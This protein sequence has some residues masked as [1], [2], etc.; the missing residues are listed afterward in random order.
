MSELAGRLAPSNGECMIVVRCVQCASLVD[1]GPFTAERLGALT[2]F[3]GMM[4]DSTICNDCIGGAFTL[5]DLDELE[6]E[7]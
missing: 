6:G 3:H 2:P 5:A 1:V 4:V 7:S